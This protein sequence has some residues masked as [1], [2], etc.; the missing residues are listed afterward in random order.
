MSYRI[1]EWDSNFFGIKVGRISCPTLRQEQLDEILSDMA[2]AHVKLAYWP[3]DTEIRSSATRELGG[4]LVDRKTTFEIDFRCLNPG[5]FISTGLVETYTPSMPVVELEALAIRS[6]QYSRFRV[7]PHISSDKFETL[8]KTWLRRSLTKQ[9]AN[10]V[11]V[12]REGGSVVGMVTLVDDQGKGEIG[13]LAVG[14]QHT[15]RRYGEILVR[16]AQ[17]GFIRNGYR[18]GQ[19]TTQANNVPA[20]NLYKKCGYSVKTVSYFYHFW[21]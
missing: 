12:I 2:R 3:S 18:F 19:V 10:E 17:V 21:L 1:L 20:C 7:D 9:I 14:P 13:L 16:A 8:Y 6:G 5:D 15:G 4:R 11:L